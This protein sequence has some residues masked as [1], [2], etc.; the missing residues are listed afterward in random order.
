M[1]WIRWR[2][3]GLV[4]RTGSGHIQTVWEKQY[5]GLGKWYK[6]QT[7]CE[8]LVFEA[9][10][11]ERAGISSKQSTYFPNF[12]CQ[13]GEKK[14]WSSRKEKEVRTALTLSAL[15]FPS[16]IY[17]FSLNQAGQNQK[18]LK[19]IWCHRPIK[20]PWVRFSICRLRELKFAEKRF[21]GYKLWPCIDVNG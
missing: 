19:P 5:V 1:K 8:L 4:L 6:M 18:A 11:A 16:G 17:N 12:L 10:P 21:A 3:S 13:F 2:P 9:K 20:L 15:L 7:F 14:G